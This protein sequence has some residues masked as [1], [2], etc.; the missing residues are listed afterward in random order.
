MEDL[1]YA[2]GIPACLNR[3]IN[4]LKDNLTVSGKTI[5]QIA[6]ISVI[7]NEDVIRPIKKAYHKT[8]GIAVLRGNIAPDGCVVKQSAVSENMMKFAGK[9]RCFDSEEAAMKSIMMGD[10][11]KN[12]VV[13]IRYEGPKGGPGMREMLSPTAAIAGMGLSD[14]VALITDGRFSGGTRGPCIGHISPEAAAGGPIAIIK[15]G[16]IIEID[17]P[18]RRIEL[19]LS[20]VKIKQR[21]KTL[22]IKKPKI[23]SG[24]LARYAKMVQSASTGAIVI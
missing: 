12:D 5:R 24:Y 19:K 4:L 16:D 17:I 9:A 6:K 20:K 22:K 14:A 21:L 3:L 15:N 7:S 23:T 18:K 2:G 11:R 1:E 13:V 10:I 8:G